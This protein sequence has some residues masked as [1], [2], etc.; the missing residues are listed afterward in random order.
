MV[1]GSQIDWGGH[2]NDQEY[3]I[4]ELI[5]FDQAVGVAL[6]FAQTHQDT[7]VIATSDHE[8]GGF[9]IH[10]GSMKQKHISDSQFTHDNHT[11]TMVPVFAY[12]IRASDFSGIA[13]NTIIGKN[14]IHFIKSHR[15]ME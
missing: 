2:A 13:D 10:Q 12:G 15:I 5:D 9:A 3:I 8:T 11:A 4:S 7:L 14:I 6:D 1:E